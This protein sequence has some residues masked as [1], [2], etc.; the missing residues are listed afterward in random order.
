M[1]KTHGI[2][3][4]G[5]TF[6]PVMAKRSKGHIDK[7]SPTNN[8]E[9]REDGKST[10]ENDE[11]RHP[12]EDKLTIDYPAEV[13]QMVAESKNNFFDDSPRASEKK[14]NDDDNRTQDSKSSLSTPVNK[15]CITNFGKRLMYTLSPKNK[16]NPFCF[17]P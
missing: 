4:E 17:T 14:K 6:Q 5:L 16:N 11:N 2:Y 9:T 13:K 7:S 12:N 15:N 8:D 3:S 1:Q 10:S